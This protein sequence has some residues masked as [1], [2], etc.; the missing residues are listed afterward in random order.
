MQA[1]GLAVRIPLVQ[2]NCKL[3]FLEQLYLELRRFKP[4]PGHH[5]E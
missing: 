3:R 5:F 2:V 4:S 1:V